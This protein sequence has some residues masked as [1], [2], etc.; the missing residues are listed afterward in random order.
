MEFAREIFNSI[1]GALLEGF[2]YEPING[3]PAKGIILSIGGSG[4]SQGGFGGPAAFSRYAQ[5]NSFAAFEWNK[6]GIRSNSTLTD[7]TVDRSEYNL[8]TIETLVNDAESAL[9]Y[10]GSKFPN[11]PV[12]VFGG[13]EGSYVTTL[14]AQK[15]PKEVCA[16][17]TFGTG[18]APFIEVIEHQLAG[19]FLATYCKENNFQFDHQFSFHELN[20]MAKVNDD[21]LPII[22]SLFPNE[23]AQSKMFSAAEIKNAVTKYWL[24]DVPNRDEYWFN[25]SAS[26]KDFFESMIKVPSM[27]DRLEKNSRPT[28]ILHGALDD[29]A[30]VQ[31]AYQLQ[32]V[33]KLIKLNNYFF[34]FYANAGHAPNPEMISDGL[35][36]FQK[37]VDK[38]DPT[39]HRGAV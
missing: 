37:N 10:V 25:T 5:S 19:Q 14:L 33:C 1:D 29:S 4:F 2:L 3:Q 34:K 8:T 23:D 6:R 16:I 12:F 32:T 24:L 7:I 30:P 31:Y 38:I 17:A 22:N 15:R 27:F 28:L 26:P 13:S 21:F 35:S 39:D 11:L 9:L 20:L 18:I 36:F